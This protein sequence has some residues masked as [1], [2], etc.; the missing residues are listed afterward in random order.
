M[1]ESNL[2]AHNLKH[3][4]KTKITEIVT[5]C[6]VEDVE[7]LTCRNCGIELDDPEVLKEHI[8]S[9]HTDPKQL[10]TN[11]GLVTTSDMDMETHLQICHKTPMVDLKQTNMMEISI[12]C[13]QCEYK[14]R[15]NKQMKK[16]KLKHS[17]QVPA[18][19]V[20][21]PFCASQSKNTDELKLHLEHNHAMKETIGNSENLSEQPQQM[22]SFSCNQCG[23]ALATSNLLQIHVTRHHTMKCRYCE[24]KAKSYG[25]L[26]GHMCEV[27]EDVIILHSMAKQ[28]DTLKVESDKQETF[29]KELFQILKIV[30]DNQEKLDNK[31]SFIQQN[32]GIAPSSKPTAG[33]SLPPTCTP[34]QT[35]PPAPTTTTRNSPQSTSTPTVN[36]PIRKKTK[37]L[38]KPKVLLIED[39]IAQNTNVAWLEKESNTRIRTKKAYSAVYDKTTR[40][41][42]KNFTDVVPDALLEAHKDD[43]YSHLVLA[44][45]SADITDIDAS[46]LTVN[47][48]IE[49]FKQNIQISC[50][51][52][53]TVATKAL[54]MNQ[55][56]EKVVLMEHPPRH[57][58][59]DDDPTGIKP[60]LAKFANATLQQ[61]LK[62]SNMKEKL[63][64]AK[65][66]LD[67]SQNMRDTI[68][69]DDGIHMYGNLGSKMFSRS[70]FGIFSSVFSGKSTNTA[71]LSTHTNCNQA[72]YQEKRCYKPHNDFSLPLRNRFEILGN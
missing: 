47:D 39:S 56:L 14:C 42:S 52:M 36:Q 15:F 61:L 35:P 60:E 46:N 49:V 21:C 22:E 24:F 27:H 11:C 51:N 53:F 32:I 54:K 45:P 62:T 57:D 29:R 28:L 25:E 8:Q 26:E 12:E 31:L 58:N 18:N 19:E 66:N 4:E 7:E 63:I 38:Q 2:V 13:D 10:C 9:V 48:N 1:T 65:H 70:V 64:V 41:P 67:F 33:P 3:I 72:V 17:K 34:S 69:K 37:F 40:Y 23:L 55:N 6:S 5:S 30:F 68:Y 20:K 71:T 16:H 43:Q 59:R 50:Q 44:A